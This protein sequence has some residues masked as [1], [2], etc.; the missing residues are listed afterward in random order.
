MR[1]NQELRDFLIE[2]LKSRFRRPGMYASSPA[3]LEE[4]TFTIFQY[5]EF[6]D[7]RNILGEKR[8][9]QK[10]LREEGL[11]ELSTGLLGRYP[12]L[13]LMEMATFL[14]VVAYKNGYYPIPRKTTD[15]ALSQWVKTPI[16]RQGLSDSDLRLVFD[17]EGNPNPVYG[18]GWK[19]E[20]V[21]YVISDNHWAIFTTT[22]YKSPFEETSNSW[23]WDQ[24][25]IFNVVTRAFF[26]KGLS[27]EGKP[28]MVTFP[29]KEL[30]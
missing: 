9:Y 25:P 2:D 16:E 7:E 23:D 5:L 27:E 18:Y 24:N 20:S 26:S 11:W 30:Y 14:S 3:S 28:F 13:S 29:P 10:I 4:Q 1:S 8:P 22:P 17:E 21:S 15:T 19:S 6:L 12:D